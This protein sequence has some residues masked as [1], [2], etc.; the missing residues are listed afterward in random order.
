MD[1]ILCHRIISEPSVLQN[2]S[3]HVFVLTLLFAGRYLQKQCPEILNVVPAVKVKGKAH[4]MRWE[5]YPSKANIIVIDLRRYNL[6]LEFY[7]MFKYIKKY[8]WFFNQIHALAACITFGIINL[9]F[10]RH[11]MWPPI[12]RTYSPWVLSLHWFRVDIRPY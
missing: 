1:W 5:V 11:F 6:K 4:W 2:T 10:L 9:L 12:C 8:F 7:F 3:E